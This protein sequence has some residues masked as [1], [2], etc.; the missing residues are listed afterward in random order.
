[1]TSGIPSHTKS[2]AIVNKYCADPEYAWWPQELVDGVK[3][4]PADFAAGQGWEYSNTNYVLLGMVIEKVLGRPV[5]DVFEQRL[6]GPL[7]M[8]DTSFPGGSTEIGNPHI[9]GLT[10][11]NQPPGK[12]ADSTR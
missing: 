12:N 5:A 3:G 4:L 1:M 7:G 8:A 6:F 9:D 10:N 2:D 11:Q